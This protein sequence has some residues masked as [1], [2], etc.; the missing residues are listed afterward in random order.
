[1]MNHKLKFLLIIGVVL[2]GGFFITSFTSYYVSRGSLRS[3]IEHSALPL[4]SD[5]VY[6]EIQRDLIKPIL[7]SSFMATDT[8][9]R[10]WAIRGEKDP[11]EISNYLNKIKL[12][13]NAVTSFFVSDKTRKYYYYGGI[14]KKVSPDAWRDKWYFRVRTMKPEYEI[15]CDPDMANSD[16]MTIFVNHKVCNYDGD[17]IGATGIGLTVN[18]VQKL[19]ERYQKKYS[20]TIYF[21][22]DTGKI[23]LGAG[24]DVPDGSNIK[25]IPGISS[26]ADKILSNN[27]STQSYDHDGKIVHLNTRFI[28]ELQWYLVVAQPEDE[29]IREIGQALVVNLLI[30]LGVTVVMLLLI[31]FSI[32]AYRKK[33]RRTENDAQA[34]IKH[35]EDEAHRKEVTIGMEIQKQLLLGEPPMNLCGAKIAAMS[36]PSQQIGGDFYDFVP[37]DSSR[38]DLFMGDVMGK[39]LSAAL[40]G[41]ATKIQF[42]RAFYNLAPVA[43]N[44]ELP[45]LERV[46]TVARDEMCGK[47]MYI[48]SFITACVARVDVEHRRLE[49]ID[50]GHTA[51]VLY[52]RATGECVQIKGP[53]CPLG[54]FPDEVYEVQTA[55]FAPGDVLM[56]YSD[57]IIE[58]KSADRTFYGMDRL[59]GF[60]RANVS[61]MPQEMMAKLCDELKTFSA[62][63]AFSDDVTCIIVKFEE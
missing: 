32:N 45:R 56:F 23:I 24:L 16:A 62:T 29:V 38:F 20:R 25:N 37:Y 31:N 15:N 9:L 48:E 18:S 5:N 36:I 35:V 3:E 51:T 4:T 63:A 57:G 26:V 59:L 7:I 61:L 13:Y 22:D 52:R 47:L 42:M 39:G 21:T 14:L 11:Q 60:I 2:L 53:N 58:A 10:D 41:A 55:D 6:S 1:M 43:E 8:F 50:C 19:I 27:S 54:F 46:V 49:I 12:K 30:S 44:G 34:G 17:F 28:V 33:I 40:C